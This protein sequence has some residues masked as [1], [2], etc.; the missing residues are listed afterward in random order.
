MQRH[1]L[2]VSRPDPRQLGFPASFKSWPPPQPTFARLPNLPQSI[3]KQALDSGQQRL[4]FRPSYSKDPVGSRRRGWT[5]TLAQLAESVLKNT[6]LIL[7][8]RN[9]RFSRQLRG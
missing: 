6:K 7:A 9:G 1:L 4:I 8:R 3:H 2:P 5:C